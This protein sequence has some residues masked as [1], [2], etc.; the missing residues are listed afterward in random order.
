MR[1]TYPKAT[2][3]PCPSAV[4]CTTKTGLSVFPGRR[5]LSSVS[6]K[7]QTSALELHDAVVAKPRRFTY[8]QLVTELPETNRPGE[9]WDGELVLSP[10]PSCRH[11]TISHR[12]H[13][14]LDDWVTA[15]ELGEVFGAPLDMVLAPHQVV[16]PDVMFVHRDRR[17]IIQRTLEG[18]ADLVAEVLSLG[19]R[20]RDRIE[21]RD[22][23]EQYAVREYWLI[24]PEAQTVEVLCLE[25]GRYQLAHRWRPGETAESRL[26]P[27]FH[28]EVDRLIGKS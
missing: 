11:Q 21:K 1:P 14:F 12:F 4:A 25:A 26:L 10:G 9:L 16:Q 6:I 18:P 20:T 3:I 24:D 28:L 27:G 8:D 23:Y 19:G 13:R 2:V 17:H 5:Y 7:Q 15:Q 22:L